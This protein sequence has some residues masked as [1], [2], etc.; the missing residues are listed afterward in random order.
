MELI[1][2]FLCVRGKEIAGLKFVNED[3][4]WRKGEVYDL[5]EKYCSHN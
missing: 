1:F 5:T 2:I 3:V 4:V